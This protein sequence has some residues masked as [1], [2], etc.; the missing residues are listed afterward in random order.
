M[1][2]LTDSWD[3]LGGVAHHK[4][5][6]NRHR[7]SGQPELPLPQGVVTS[8]GRV[9]NRIQMLYNS[10]AY[11]TFLPPNNNKIICQLAVDC[12]VKTK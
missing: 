11:F 3:N 12:L 9:G 2:Y 8:P 1:H 10:A 4:D 6:D 5:Q 7:D